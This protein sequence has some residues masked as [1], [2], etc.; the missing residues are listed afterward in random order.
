[1]TPANQ[2]VNVA[3]I[4]I[5]HGFV[6]NSFYF[7]STLF[8]HPAHFIILY[9]RFTCFWMGTFAITRIVHLSFL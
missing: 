4:Y 8:I 2:M 1:M 7:F 6:L 5:V 3:Q 9:V